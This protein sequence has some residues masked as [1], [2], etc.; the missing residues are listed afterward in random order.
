MA[1]GPSSARRLWGYREDL[2][3]ALAA[4][5]PVRKLDVSLPASALAGFVERVP[6]LVTSVD[7]AARCW[8]FGHAGDG[9]LHVNIT[10]GDAPEERFA[11]PIHRWVVDAGGSISAEHGIGRSKR[12][13]R[14]LMR[15]AGDLE[16][17]RM[18]RSVFDPDGICNPAAGP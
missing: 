13:W 16:A 6:D 11:D 7:A 5:G 14:H 4:S 10:G 2:P 8:L 3:A 17:M 18:L 9:N 12:P 15:S 1:D